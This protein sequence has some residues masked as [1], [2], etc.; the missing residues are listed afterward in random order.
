MT[1]WA[2]WEPKHPPAARPGSAVSSPSSPESQASKIN[3]HV[4]FIDLSHDLGPARFP[5][6]VPPHR[7]NGGGRVGRGTGMVAPAAQGSWHSQPWP[8]HGAAPRSRDAPITPLG[9]A[10]AVPVLASISP[11]AQARCG[12]PQRASRFS[13]FLKLFRLSFLN[14]ISR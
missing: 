10:P 13:C 5:S 9:H 14:L 1:R 11:L 8:C 12:R 2:D 4:L 3:C 7:S 6:P